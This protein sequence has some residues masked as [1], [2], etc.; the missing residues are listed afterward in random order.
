MKKFV[1]IQNGKEEPVGKYATKAEAADVMEQII[2]D[3]NDD[4]DS[5]DEN[6]LTAFDFRLEEV[7]LFQYRANMHLSG[8]A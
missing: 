7:G 8:T 1:L 6:Y 4:L 2:D 3:N 5:D